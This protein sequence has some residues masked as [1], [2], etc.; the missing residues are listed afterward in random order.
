MA[1]KALPI[2]V[3]A[4]VP[5][6]LTACR[7]TPPPPLTPTPQPPPAT[8][9]GAPTLPP[10]EPTPTPSPRGETGG[11]AFARPHERPPAP[12]FHLTLFTGEEVSL[13][14]LQGR[15]VVLNF[16][17]SWCPPCRAEMPQLE[18]AWWEWQE[19]GVI[20]LGIATGD[21][22]ER[23][24]A[25]AREV[26]ATYPLALDRDGRSTLA[27]RVTALPTTYFIDRRGGMARRI[28]GYVPEGYL[29][30]MLSLLVEEEG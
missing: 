26:G 27:Y 8:P 2:V 19:R 29:R 13:S 24:M 12:D 16:W 7:G 20:I 30:F 11:R 1:G 25:F 14:S 5:L 3:A 10:P 4:L 28:V 9:E 17:A 21:H 15:V 6:V 22:P 23:A 18:R